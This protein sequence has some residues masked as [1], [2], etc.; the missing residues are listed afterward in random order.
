MTFHPIRVKKFKCSDCIEFYKFKKN[1]KNQC[2]KSVFMCNKCYKCY[3]Y[4]RDMIVHIEINHKNKI[5]SLQL[6]CIQ[7][8]GENCEDKDIKSLPL[9]QS[10]KEN[11]INKVVYDNGTTPIYY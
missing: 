7:I 9:P 5:Q 6:L 2:L 11:I 8:I 4:F 3:T 10:I 1:N